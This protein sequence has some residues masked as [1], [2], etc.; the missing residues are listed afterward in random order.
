MGSPMPSG[1][2]LTAWT[3]A[4]VIAERYP[5]WHTKLLVYGLA[6]TVSVSRVLARDHFPSDVLVGRDDGGT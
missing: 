4:H 6:S 2:S 1:H 5:S 3:F